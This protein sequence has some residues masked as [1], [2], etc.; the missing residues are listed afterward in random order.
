[1]TVKIIS[2]PVKICSFI[3]FPMCFKVRNALIFEDFFSEQ[4]SLSLIIPKS[5]RRAALTIANT[6]FTLCAER[7]TELTSFAFIS[8]KGSSRS[9]DEWARSKQRAAGTEK[10]WPRSLPITPFIVSKRPY[11]WEMLKLLRS[12]ALW[13]HCNTR[14]SLSSTRV[15]PSA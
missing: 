12:F 1:M 14:T 13:I 2:K 8:K 5:S 4:I 9:N 10:K 7:R 11:M 6:P 15:G 3:I